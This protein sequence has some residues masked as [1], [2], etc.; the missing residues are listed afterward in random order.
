MKRQ[1]ENVFGNA[2]DNLDDF[3]LASQI[4]Q[5]EANKF[6]IEHTRARM[7]RQGGLIWWNLVD[8]WP[9]FSD[10]VVDYYYNKKLAYEYIKRSQQN[11]IVM[12]DEMGPWDG[13]PV[14]CANNV[15]EP[16]CGRVRITNLETDEILFE[17]EFFAEPFKATKIGAIN[18]KRSTK[19]MLKIE[20]VLENG[21]KG[22]NH[23][24]LGTPPLSLE[25]YKKWYSKL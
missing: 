22:K 14:L 21:T 12:M 6:F 5:A 25:D 18:V 17:K 2:P 7:D 15:Y 13:L 4:C 3:I 24:L 8:G 9:Q 16:V 11:F 20:W 23:Y 10:A 19:G 1:V